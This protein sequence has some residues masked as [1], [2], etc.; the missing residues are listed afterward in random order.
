MTF[1]LGVG[2]FLFPSFFMTWHPYIP[3]HFIEMIFTLVAFLSTF[4][5]WLNLDLGIPMCFFNGLT[6]YVKTWLQF[7][8]PLYILALV[9]VI[10]IGS[11]YSTRVTRLIGTNAVSVLATLVLLSYTKILRIVISAFSFTTLTAT[12]VWCGW[13]MATFSTLNPSTPFSS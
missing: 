6:T 1:C 9:G 4:I 2:I 5:A 7:V 12:I 8:F 13:L 11:N 3:L 10:I